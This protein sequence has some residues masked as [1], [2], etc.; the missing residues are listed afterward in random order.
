MKISDFIINVISPNLF[1]ESSKI[2]FVRENDN[3]ID[4]K[5]AYNILKDLENQAFRNH[6]KRIKN[7]T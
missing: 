2:N 3:I 5:E 7:S 1:F 6:Y 4:E